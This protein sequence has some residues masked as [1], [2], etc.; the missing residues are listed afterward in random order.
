MHDDYGGRY[1]DDVTIAAQQSNTSARK[2]GRSV[3]RVFYKSV[4]VVISCDDDGM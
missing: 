1:D 2:L 4:V 3:T